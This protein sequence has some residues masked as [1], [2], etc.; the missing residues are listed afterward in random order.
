[1]RPDY[2]RRNVRMGKR[3]EAQIELGQTPIEL[4]ILPSQSRDELPPILA[5]LQW[6]FKTP[7]LNEAIFKLLEE[8]VVGDKQDTGRPGMDLWH[9][10]V[11]GV[12]R[13]GLNCDYDR[14]E[15]MVNFDGLVRK[16]MGLPAFGTDEESFH[17]KTI[18][19]N[20]C[21]IDEV[22][23]KKI[24]AIVVQHGL[25]HFTKKNAAA[26]L[27]PG[28]NLEVKIDSY[29]LETNVH[30][31]TDTNLLWDAA[32]KSIEI[33]GSLYEKLGLSGWRKKAYWKRQ[34]KN[35]M[36]ACS[37]A[38]AGGGANKAERVRA[39]AEDYLEAAYALEKKVNECVEEL[40][41]TRL[42]VLDGC[43]LEQAVYFQDHLIRHIDLVER[44]LIRGESIPHA[45]KVFS[46]FEEH[47]DLIKKGKAMPPVEFGR[48]LLIATA[49][50]GLI[51]DYKVMGGGSESA[52]VVPLVDRLLSLF[53]QD[54]I[55]SLSTDKGFSS[56]ADRELL[57][58]YIP[59]VIMPKK[60]RKS[61]ADQERQS[62]PRWT[63]LKHAHSAVESDINCLE[64]HGLNRCPDKGLHGYT[65]YVGL[66]VLAYNLHKIGAQ[67][68]A[69]ERKATTKA[70]AKTE[71]NTKA[72]PPARKQAA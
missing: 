47:T 13:L 11:L 6:I 54:S 30:Y 67:L 68:L 23:L 31:P 51:L 60:G 70:K 39:A 62:A 32:R 56:V 59:E 65:R 34:L 42:S 64:H 17:H 69:T 72:E 25:G 38:A 5:G 10:L 33:L 19:D 15:H 49:A 12:V 35:A 66:G 36:R 48:R 18:S 57:E 43:R 61:Q 63:R 9:I 8:K 40:R 46:L 37:R 14:L 1:M 16:M 58:L 50:C 41:A 28:L 2:S 44:R 55:R 3:F 21:H 45:Q 24:N 52:E 29:V 22:L 26:N 7:E 53:G 27:G 71:A 4:V 20:I